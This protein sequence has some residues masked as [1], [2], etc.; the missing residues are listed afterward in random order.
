VALPEAEWVKS[1]R[2]CG[3]IGG[4]KFIAE[5]LITQI[6]HP[7][8]FKAPAGLATGGLAVHYFSSWTD[9][10][11]IMLGVISISLILSM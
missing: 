10:A 7:F 4:P 9:A 1:L 11:Q 8:R 2:P 6:E 5:G 3:L